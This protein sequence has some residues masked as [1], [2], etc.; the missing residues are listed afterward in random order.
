MG[1][2]SF[3]KHP[4]WGDNEDITPVS[5]VFRFANGVDRERLRKSS[6]YEGIS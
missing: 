5:R 6:S 1:I 4:F 3:R 2:S